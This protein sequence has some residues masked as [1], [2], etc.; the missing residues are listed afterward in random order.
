MAMWGCDL[1]SMICC[2]ASSGAFIFF[3]LILYF[4]KLVLYT[5][6]LYR[7]Q[8]WIW[9]TLCCKYFIRNKLFI[10]ESLF[11]KGIGGCCEFFMAQLSQMCFQFDFWHGAQSSCWP[12]SYLGSSFQLTEP[13]LD[14]DCTQH[15]HCKQ[16]WEK[17]AWVSAELPLIWRKPEILCFFCGQCL[18]CFW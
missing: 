9:V 12:K 13:R 14:F 7:L 15:T 11:H 18:S 17:Y 10:Q 3:L 16:W 1:C 4:S 8:G 5:G 2:F 6:L